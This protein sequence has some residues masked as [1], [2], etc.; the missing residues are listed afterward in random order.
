MSGVEQ[1]RENMAGLSKDLH[2]NDILRWTMAEV[3]TGI[4]P[5]IWAAQSRKWKNYQKANHIYDI[6]SICSE[7]YTE[8]AI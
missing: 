6:Y 4:A 7:N 3:G 8:I 2:D 5:L 1:V